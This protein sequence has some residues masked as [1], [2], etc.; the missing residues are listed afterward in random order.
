MIFIIILIPRYVHFSMKSGVGKLLPNSDKPCLFV[1]ALVQL[2]Y[3][4][5]MIRK[6]KSIL[7]FLTILVIFLQKKTLVRC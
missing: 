4:V 7:V 5:S 2:T 3:I 6:I 1:Y